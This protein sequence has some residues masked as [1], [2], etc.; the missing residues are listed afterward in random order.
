[1][2]QDGLDGARSESPT[3]S[4]LLACAGRTLLV[5]VTALKMGPRPETRGWRLPG[6]VQG[7]AGSGHRVSELEV[8]GSA[9]FRGEF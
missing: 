4:W 6:A 8:H 3:P 5:R 2:Q 9:P 1:M 7:L